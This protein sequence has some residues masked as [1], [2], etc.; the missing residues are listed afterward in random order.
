MD[1]NQILTEGFI[2]LCNDEA[3]FISSLICNL[4]KLWTSRYTSCSLIVDTHLETDSEGISEVKLRSSQ[5]AV[6]VVHD[7]SAKEITG[8]HYLIGVGLE[9]KINQMVK[10]KILLKWVQSNFLM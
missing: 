8:N 2:A 3:S 6:V 10:R 7:V 5:H 4:I 1:K 9:N